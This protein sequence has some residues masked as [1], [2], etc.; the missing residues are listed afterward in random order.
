L[1]TVTATK[2]EAILLK[3]TSVARV[4]AEILAR[5]KSLDASRDAKLA[6]QFIERNAKTLGQFG[7]NARVDFN[8]SNVFVVFQSGPQIGEPFR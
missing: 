1:G 7:I 5:S 6:H 8:G 3:D 2:A 4:G